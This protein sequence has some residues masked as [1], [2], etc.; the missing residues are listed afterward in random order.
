MNDT[1][2]SVTD[3]VRPYFLKRYVTLP[4]GY[5][6]LLCWITLM[7]WDQ[8]V[9]AY[10][11]H[12]R[13]QPWITAKIEIHP[14]KYGGKP[15]IGYLPLPKVVLRGQWKAWTEVGGIRDCGGGNN[16]SYRPIEDIPKELP[17]WTWL[18][19]F[20][21]DCPVPT[22]P[23]RICLSYTVTTQSNVLNKF[24]SYCSKVHDPSVVYKERPDNV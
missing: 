21:K 9:E 4:W 11:T 18:G 6:I 16:G 20:E 23:F 2:R 13:P 19:F 1:K 12:V 14:Q 22:K 17:I 24:G 8:I 7:T 10:D 15:M 3:N 5:I